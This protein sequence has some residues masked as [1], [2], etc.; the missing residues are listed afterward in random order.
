[1]PRGMLS[2]HELRTVLLFG[3]MSVVG[4]TEQPNILDG[5]NAA[6]SKRPL[7]MKLEKRP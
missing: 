5:V 3:E 7:M 2:F 4:S 6:F 1:M